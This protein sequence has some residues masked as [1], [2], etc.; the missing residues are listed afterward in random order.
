MVMMKYLSPQRSPATSVSVLPRVN[1]VDRLLMIARYLGGT[2]V[3]LLEAC[4]L[5]TFCSN[6]LH[7]HLD[8]L[9]LFQPQGGTVVCVCDSDIRFNIRGSDR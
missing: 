6:N 5:D 3:A 9:L 8:R 1:V 2:L 4:A 7:G